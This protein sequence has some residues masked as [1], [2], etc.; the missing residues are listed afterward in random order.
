LNG[1]CIDGNITGSHF[2]RDFMVDS[3]MDTNSKSWNGDLLKQV[4][5]KDITTSILNMPLINHV[6]NYKLVWKAEK[7]VC[8]L[9]EVHTGYGLRIWLIRLI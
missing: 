7:M 4:F 2:V 8:I 3:L 1:G 6:P 9:S 5:S